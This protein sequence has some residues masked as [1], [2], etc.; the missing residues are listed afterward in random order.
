MSDS[1]TLTYF[2]GRGLG[3]IIR[4]LFVIAKVPYEDNRLT[5]ETWTAGKAAGDFA[6]NMDR[7]PILTYNGHKIGQS[8]A[9]ER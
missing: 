5:G 4:F 7:V 9:I 8:R 2:N 6:L 3:E 1:Y